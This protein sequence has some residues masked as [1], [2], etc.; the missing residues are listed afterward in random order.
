MRLEAE[1]RGAEEAAL[2]WALRQKDEAAHDELIAK[3]FRGFADY[4]NDPEK[5]ETVF[6]ELLRLLR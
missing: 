6:E 1:R 3:V 4:D 2:L 5:L